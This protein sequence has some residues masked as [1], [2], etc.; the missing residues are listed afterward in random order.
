MQQVW[1]SVRFLPLLVV[2]AACASPVPVAQTPAPA[3]ASPSASV[4]VSPTSS[5]T[6]SP[7]RTGPWRTLTVSGSGDILIHPSLWGHA[8]ADGGASGP[9]FVQELTGVGPIVKPADYSVC[10]VE[11]GFNN[12]AGPVTE[13][14]NYY[15]HPAL[16][17]A[18]AKTGFDTCSTASN[19]TFLKG[20]EGI[21]RTNT[22]LNRAGV[23]AA[24]S[25]AKRSQELLAVDEVNGITVAHISSTDPADSPAVPDAPWAI[26]R[27]T[28]DE[29]IDQATG[30]RSDGA[31]VVIVSLAMGQ[32]GSSA[33]T[34]A[35]RK[36][37]RKIAKSGAVDLI[38]GHGSHTMQG[39]ENIDGVWVIWHGNLLTSFFPD[40]P[41]M[42]EGLVSTVTLAEQPDGKF[43]ATKARG[44]IVLSLPQS[45]RLTVVGH[46]SCDQVTVREQEAYN[47][48]AAV[49]KTAIAQGF[50]LT[51]PC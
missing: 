27:A 40:Q 47:A 50:K 28:A 32:M 41:R 37:A 36:T 25:R 49:M 11:Q 16:A 48:T 6:P 23:S 4:A 44:D 5:S 20:L 45:G 30:A 8:Q 24:G 35:Q 17:T 34:D 51:K 42:H 29:I 12:T 43:V 38:V 46:Q 33:P 2:L 18:I 22:S 1:S 10:H 19:W 26:N 9:S 39:A 31:Q 3:T 14:P 13:Y 21:D 15:T 7:T